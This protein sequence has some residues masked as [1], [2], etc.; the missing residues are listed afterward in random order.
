MI[1]TRIAQAAA[2]ATI[3]LTTLL[4]APTAASATADDSIGWGG[5]V[6]TAGAPATDDSIGWGGTVAPAGIG[7]GGTVAPATNG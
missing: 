6:A 2:V 7:W 1:R 5:T 3:A 4:I